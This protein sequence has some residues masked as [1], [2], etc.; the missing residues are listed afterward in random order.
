[1]LV[2]ESNGSQ[3][4][5][6]FSSVAVLVLSAYG[7]REFESVVNRIACPPK[8]GGAYG[9]REFESVVNPFAFVCLEQEAYGRREFE[10]VVNSI[11]QHIS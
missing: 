3:T 8:A 6:P 2:I 7:R 11:V 4:T 10:S 5:Y 1:M 9:R